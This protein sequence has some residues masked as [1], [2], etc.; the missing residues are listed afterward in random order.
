MEMVRENQN[1]PVAQALIN[2]LGSGNAG[3]PAADGD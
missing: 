1:D 3:T 2:E